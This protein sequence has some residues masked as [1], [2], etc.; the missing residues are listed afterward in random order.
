MQR[1]ELEAVKRERA[2]LVEQLAQVKTDQGK[3]GGDLQEEDIQI[4]RREIELKKAKLNELYE[5]CLK[6]HFWLSLS[7]LSL[8]L[9]T[10]LI[11]H[12][13]I[14]PQSAPHTA[15]QRPAGTKQRCQACQ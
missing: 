13:S 8:I 10:Y 6:Q 2:H 1:R 12:H 15:Q 7:Y 3:A 11:K 9:Q 4:L 14:A 5:A